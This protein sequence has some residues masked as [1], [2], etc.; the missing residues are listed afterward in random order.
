MHAPLSGQGVS[1]KQMP[2][3]GCNPRC[4]R[5]QILVCER[6]PSYKFVKRVKA[7]PWVRSQMLKATEAPWLR[8]QTLIST[9]DLQE[10]SHHMAARLW[11]GRGRERGGEHLRLNG[12]MAVG[13]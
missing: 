9:A 11:S 1:Y 13:Q 2:R 5:E 4:C 8:S 7:A 12:G 10:A 6:F 3:F